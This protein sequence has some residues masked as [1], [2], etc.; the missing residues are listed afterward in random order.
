MDQEQK[1]AEG[2]PASANDPGVNDTGLARNL[3]VQEEKEAE[4]TSRPSSATF[5]KSD[6][7]TVDNLTLWVC[8]TYD[9]ASTIPDD[10]RHRIHSLDELL[11]FLRAKRNDLKNGS[12]GDK[13]RRMISVPDVRESVEYCREPLQHCRELMESILNMANSTFTSISFYQRPKKFRKRVLLSYTVLMSA[14]DGVKVAL[15]SQHVNSTASSTIPSRRSI[16]AMMERQVQA[17]LAA[18]A[19]Q[20]IGGQAAAKRDGEDESSPETLCNIAD[21]LMSGLGSVQSPKLAATYYQRAADKGYTRAMNALAAMQVKGSGMTVNI[22]AARELFLASAK[23]GD[24][25]GMNESAKL[26]IAEL[27]TIDSCRN[28]VVSDA[29]RKKAISF[30]RRSAIQGHLDAMTNAG[31]V[32]LRCSKPAPALA[33]EWFRKAANKGYVRAQN[34]LGTVLLRGGSCSRMG[35]RRRPLGATEYEIKPYQDL[36]PRKSEGGGRRGQVLAE[37]EEHEEELAMDAKEASLYF[38]LAAEAG[39]PTACNNL[40]IL[41]ERGEGVPKNLEAAA[42]L[43]RRASDKGHPAAR[44]NLGYVLLRMSAQVGLDCPEGR[45]MIEKAASLF[46][47][48]IDGYLN[49]GSSIGD[50]VGSVDSARGAPNPASKGFPP[51]TRGFDPTADAHYNLALLF[52]TGRG[53]P[54]DPKRAFEHAKAAADS[55]QGCV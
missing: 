48:S 22:E 36:N 20:S 44:N 29:T 25:D 18:G 11:H 8:R 42:D 30:L 52:S 43:Y 51:E 23:S 38:R 39:D 53:V 45:I 24:L 49:A 4:A 16:N 40:G 10:I 13:L 55:R 1:N 12:L 46:R 37:K 34:L 47:K 5:K 33:A 14:F 2:A 32:C 41:Y 19:S 6:A 50:R 28:T 54:N 17:I 9:K 26:G 21:R 31:L 27:F 35:R 3:R 7:A 15:A